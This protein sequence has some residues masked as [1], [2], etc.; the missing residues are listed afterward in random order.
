MG[1]YVTKVCY[2]TNPILT[3]LILQQLCSRELNTVKKP[4]G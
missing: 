4:V 2:Y 3:Y 1:Y